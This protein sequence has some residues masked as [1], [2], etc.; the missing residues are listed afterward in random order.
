MVVWC[1]L[2]NVLESG[3]CGV[4]DMNKWK[5]VTCSYILVYIYGEKNVDLDWWFARASVY[6]LLG[7]R[8][9]FYL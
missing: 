7:K 4:V 5:H 9:L 6:Q 3:G 2:I 8:C 1:V